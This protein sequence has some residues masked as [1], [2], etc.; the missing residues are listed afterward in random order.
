VGECH[1]SNRR[2]S[3]KHRA[4][5]PSTSRTRTIQER[6]KRKMSKS[7]TGRQ[8]EIRWKGGGPLTN[9][10]GVDS[11]GKRGRQ[12]TQEKKRRSPK[13]KPHAQNDE[14]RRRFN[15]SILP[16]RKTKKGT[17]TPKKHLRRK[18]PLTFEKTENREG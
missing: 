18:E 13:E 16:L 9:Y 12:K 11:W 1:P 3:S 8:E 10:P 7:H 15:P 5:L 14:G 17:S 2:G 4:A 6:S